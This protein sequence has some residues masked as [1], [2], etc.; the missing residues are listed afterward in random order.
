MIYAGVPSLFDLVLEDG[1]VP[2]FLP[3][4]YIGV[5]VGDGRWP[6]ILRFFGRGKR[7]KMGAPKQG[8]QGI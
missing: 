3:L 8:T 7:T 2:T 4:L 1:H 6:P 5:V